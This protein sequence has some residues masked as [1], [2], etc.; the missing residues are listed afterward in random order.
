[1]FRLRYSKQARH[2]CEMALLTRLGSN[3]TFIHGFIRPLSRN[4]LE[5]QDKSKQIFLSCRPYYSHEVGALRPATFLLL[6]NSRP[7][8]TAFPAAADK[9][10]MLRTPIGPVSDPKPSGRDRP[11]GCP[12]STVTAKALWR[13]RR[14]P[15][16]SRQSQRRC[17]PGLGMQEIAVE[18]KLARGDVFISRTILNFRLTLDFECRVDGPIYGNNI[19]D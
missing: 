14:D 17:V 8:S 6:K 11:A 18:I 12:G 2:V 13:E 19:L 7:V 9:R 15:Q 10:R 5:T 3:T 16:S 1:M 4:S